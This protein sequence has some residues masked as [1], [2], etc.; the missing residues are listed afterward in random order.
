MCTTRG[1]ELHGNWS[2][3]RETRGKEGPEGEGEGEGPRTPTNYW[4]L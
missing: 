2:R 3:K 4:Y 1:D